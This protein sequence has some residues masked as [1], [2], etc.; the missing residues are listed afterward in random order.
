VVRFHLKGL[1]VV[2]LFAAVVMLAVDVRLGIAAI[3]AAAVI[4]WLSLAL[5]LGLGQG[6]D[7]RSR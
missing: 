6:R 5:P 7:R 3:V 2:A 1:L 4:D